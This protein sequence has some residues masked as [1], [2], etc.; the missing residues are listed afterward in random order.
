MK[1]LK[2][3]LAITMAATMVLGVVPVMADQPDMEGIPAPSVNGDYTPPVYPNGPNGGEYAGALE[4]ANFRS[5]AGVVTD[6]SPVVNY[7]G[8]EAYGEKY[9][10]I[11][12][13][14]NGTVVFLVDYHTFVLGDAIELGDN[15]TGYF[16]TGGFMTLQYPPTHHARLIINREIENVLIDRFYF[17]EEFDAL[18][19]ADNQL[20]LN[21]T[22]ETPIYLQDGQVFEPIGHDTMEEALDGR[23]LVVIYSIEDRMLPGGTIPADPSLE[24]HV[25]F[26]QPAIS[27][28]YIPG[29]DG[30]EDYNDYEVDE[31]ED[32]EI[33]FVNHGIA[34]NGTML[35]ETWVEANE[36]FY[37]PF[38][39]VINAIGFGDTIEWDPSI[40]LITVS[41]EGGTAIV[42]SPDN[43]NAFIAGNDIIELD[44]PAILIG[45]VTYVPMQFFTRV[46]AMNNAFIQGGQIFINND[47]AME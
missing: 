42:F 6:I 31:D 9:V 20:R 17:N 3:A 4:S 29:L 46:F 24:V 34:V 36:T 35:E 33:E 45:D 7:A 14:D 12:T 39:A 25:L 38:R 15:I 21:F 40:R 37:V 11:N 2:K 41:N 30:D 28:P 44:Y 1:K 10:T 13:D 16:S 26:E 27:P 22:E 32:I 8:D 19:S 5:Y 43:D 23:L 47:E 18:I